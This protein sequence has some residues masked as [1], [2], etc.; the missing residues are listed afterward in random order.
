MTSL[1]S[2]LRMNGYLVFILCL[3][4]LSCSQESSPASVQQTFDKGY[5]QI[6][7]GGPYAGVEFHKSRPV[8]S[9]VSFYYPVANSLDLSTDYWK[10]YNSQPLTITVFTASDSFSIG[11]EGWKY[12]YGPHFVEFEKR[13]NDYD[14]KISYRFGGD[15]PIVALAMDI[16]GTSS[17]QI[18]EKVTVRWALSLRTSHAYRWLNDPQLEALPGNDFAVSYS[19]SG[20]ANAALFISNVTKNAP[21]WQLDLGSKPAVEFSFD[22]TAKKPQAFHLDQ[23]MGMCTKAELESMVSRVNKDWQNSIK[24]YE[25]EVNAYATGETRLKVNDEALQNTAYWSKAIQRANRHYIDGSLMPMPC[26]A[27][28]NFFFTHDLLLTGLGVV[29]YDLEYI[30]EG[31]KFLLERTKADHVLPHAYYWREGE[32]VTEYCNS[33]NWNHLWIVI[34]AASYL[35]HSADKER[36]SELYPIL[37]RSINLMLENLGEDGL[38]YAKR[39]DWWDIGN[40]Y[41]PRTYITV[42]TGKALKDFVY[43]SHTLEKSTE[44]LPTY[45]KIAENLEDE[46]VKQLWSDEYKYLMNIMDDGELDSHY[47]TGSM[48]AVV[49]GMLDQVHS[50]ALME[51]VKDTLLD[52]HLGVRNAM[53]PDFH[54]LGDRY[55]FAGNEAGEQWVYFNGGVWPQGNAWYVNALCA[56]GQ[57]ELALSAMKDFMTIEGIAAS[58]N[59]TPSFYEYRRTDP[60]SPR[61]GEIDKPTFL[62]AGGFYLQSLYQLLGFRENSWNQYFHVGIPE[63][64]AETE[65]DLFIQGS[66][67]RVETNGRGKWFEQIWVDGERS[68]SAVITKPARKI[69][70]V[71]GKLISPYLASADAEI[72]AVQMR[73]SV[74]TIDFQGV[75][76]QHFNFELASPQRLSLLNAMDATTLEEIEPQYFQ[77]EGTLKQ[78]INRVELQFGK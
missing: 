68:Y 21:S 64:L 65:A 8:P 60:N 45:L 14:I 43:I 20:S 52:K 27:E 62:W 15:L 36:V 12:T 44:L 74:L 29:K 3:G 6:E 22:L 2:T 76:G 54:L 78:G 11:T 40:V 59:G 41:G 4:I 23:I 51:T 75:V 46:L 63:S 42:L 13:V 1:K 49:Y 17:S 55:H 19:D 77:L 26:P 61:Y 28:Y 31:Y 10:R 47:Y 72:L 33:D 48:L 57:Y 50:R 58:P 37:E 9:R 39:P 73:D 25:Q 34:S 71:R 67:C 66:L 56:S 5:G 38:M 16:S 35:K 70:L 18:I 69:K 7:V 30:S 53:P 32:F 24:Q